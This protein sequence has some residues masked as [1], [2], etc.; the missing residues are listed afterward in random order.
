MGR[1]MSRRVG[2]IPIGAA[3]QLRDDILREFA[4]TANERWQA[5][6]ASRGAEAAGG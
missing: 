5:R 2:T 4:G 1:E 3:V 6:P